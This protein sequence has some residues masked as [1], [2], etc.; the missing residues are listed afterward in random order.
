MSPIDRL[1]F[2][3]LQNSAVRMDILDNDP[4]PG[5][6]KLYI[7][8]LTTNEIIHQ[9]SFP[10]NV[11]SSTVCNQIPESYFFFFFFVFIRPSI[12]MR[13]CVLCLLYIYVYERKKS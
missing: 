3:N 1:L 10:E 11:A 6:P 4:I 5:T 12:Y 2:F 7:L 9:H 13:V 8:D